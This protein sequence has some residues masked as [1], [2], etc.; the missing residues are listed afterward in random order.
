MEAIFLVQERTGLPSISTVQAPQ[1]PMPQPTFTP[2]RPIRRRTV[3]SLSF[4][5][6]TITKRFTPLIS[7]AILVSLAK[8]IILSYENG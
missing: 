6:S 7:K 4:S 2:V 3:E 8:R 5:G 1:T